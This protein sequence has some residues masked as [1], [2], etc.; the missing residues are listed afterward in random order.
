MVWPRPE[1][2]AQPEKANFFVERSDYSRWWKPTP[3]CAGGRAVSRGRAAAKGGAARRIVRSAP[4][5]LLWSLR[6]PPPA[7]IRLHLGA[8]KT[9]TTHIQV[10]L[11]AHR[12]AL[13][14]AGV[15]VPPTSALRAL[16]FPLRAS[17][18]G[19]S[20]ETASSRRLFGRLNRLR[21]GAETM[22]ISDE[23]WLSGVPDALAPEPYPELERPLR[24]MAPLL[25]RA[26]LRLFLGVRNMATFL[27]SAYV[28]A[29]RFF[30]DTP[31]F[32]AVARAR[33]E[34]GASWLGP[35]RRLKALFPRAPLTIWRYEDYRGRRREILSALCGCDVGKPPDPPEPAATRSPSAEAVAEAEALTR[36]GLPRK[37]YLR[38]AQATLTLR[39]GGKFAP[40]AEEE[41]RW[42]ERRYEEDLAALSDMPGVTLLRFPVEAEART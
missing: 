39:S 28:E 41:R 32:E 33:R 17:G 13:A 2:G 6:R 11:A 40:F 4:I 20:F 25:R 19:R 30:P 18:D 12:D 16:G 35:V 29:L 9:A 27:P 38:R 5:D 10:T 42:F 3:A 23:R 37:E 15:D 26:D 22:V 34:S 1:R 8:H 7:Q 14:A 36:L 21:R 31:P 24:A